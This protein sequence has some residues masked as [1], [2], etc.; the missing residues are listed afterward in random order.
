VASEE[1]RDRAQALIDRLWHAHLMKRKPTLEWRP[2]RT[3]A[4][5]AHFDRWAISLS[6]HVLDTPEKLDSTL[7][8]EYAHLLA[9]DRHGMK[10]AN[11]GI[12]WKA[13][14]AELGEEAEVRH[15]YTVGRNQSRQVVVYRCKKCRTEFE[16][17]RKLPKRRKYLHRACGGSIEYVET[18][19][20]IPESVV[21]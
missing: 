17:K 13:A 10:A 21:S 12:Y 2:Y 11:H 6:I 14:M 5:K 3:T 4:G 18:R 15:R 16:R 20:A 7:K 1:L 8:H 19:L 9:V